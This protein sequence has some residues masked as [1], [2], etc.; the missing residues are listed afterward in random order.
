M[1]STQKIYKI[2]KKDVR[3]LT[4]INIDYNKYEDVVSD[5]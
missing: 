3:N 1:N 2:S 4:L 5:K